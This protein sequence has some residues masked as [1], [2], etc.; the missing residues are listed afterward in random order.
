MDVRQLRNVMAVIES[1]S[2]G[3]ASEALHISQPALTKSIHRLEDQLGVPLFYRDARGMR[4]TVYGECMRA[5]AQA[6]TISVAQA[7]EEIEAL[8]AGSQGVLNVAAPPLIATEIV[9]DAVTR[10]L[11]DKPRL[12]VRVFTYA[13]DMVPGLLAG[14]FDFIVNVVTREPP[15]G[16]EQK[17][18]FDDRLVVLARKGHPIT[19][20]RKILPRDVQPLDWILPIH[21]N[22]H[23]R[24]LES[25]FEA[26]GLPPPRPIIECID[27]AFMRRAVRQ[28][29]HLAVIAKIGVPDARGLTMIELQSPFMAREI[30]VMWRRHSVLSPSSKLL[31]LALD[32]VCRERAGRSRARGR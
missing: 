22:L 5:H 26:E 29:D 24:R 19:R 21:P 1:G 10:L 31:M 8:K 15:L 9:A 27:T 25:L 16:I 13:T 18:L 17:H 2:V 7:L 3:K 20:L 4:P 14:E 30:G 23:R 28:S 32:A 11:L 12:Q 6:V